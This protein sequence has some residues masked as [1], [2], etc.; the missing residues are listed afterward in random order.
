MMIPSTLPHPTAAPDT[1][2]TST[3]ADTPEFTKGGCNS[4]K[5]P[6]WGVAPLQR[7]LMRMY[8]EFAIFYLVVAGLLVVIVPF[9]GAQDIPEPPSETT[10]ATD[11]VVLA[12]QSAPVELTFLEQAFARGD[13]AEI[14]KFSAKHLD[15]TLFGSS[16]L[17]SRSQA[18]YVLKAFFDEYRPEKLLLT[19]M[20]GSEA[21]WF[22]A[23]SYSYVT[24]DSHLAVYLRLRRGDFG[25]ELREVRIGRMSDR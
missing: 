16:E 24:G 17:Y 11:S 2:G 15:I 9:A 1:R 12:P 25:W 18:G 22:A 3:S 8:P 5:N 20:S 19:E 4:Y 21:N 7:I 14:M 10:L 13:A 23:G 6:F